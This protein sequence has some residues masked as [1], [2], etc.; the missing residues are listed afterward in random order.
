MTLDWNRLAR[1]TSGER[2]QAL[3]DELDSAM[4]SAL[5]PGEEA[6][7]LRQ[8]PEPLRAMWLMN[9]LD[10]EVSQGSLL[11]YFYNSHGRFAVETSD[12]LRR[13]GALRM[14][15]VLD[16]ARDAAV[17]L[18]EDDPQAGTAAQPEY[19]IRTAYSGQPDMDRMAA[20]TELYW[21][22]A[23]DDD[24]GDKFDAYIA[25]EVLALAGE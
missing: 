8:L 1:M 11:A 4:G 18:A 10:F 7:R 25:A 3:L 13:I 19:S 16:Q 17:A 5:E 12:L 6:R 15:G 2:Q 24:W 9:W 23:T 14:A 22:A 20:L 21:A